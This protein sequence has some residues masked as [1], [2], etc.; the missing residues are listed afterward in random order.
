GRYNNCAR[1]LPK[2]G[3]DVL[4]CWP[5]REET[6]ADIHDASANGRHGQIIN[7]ATWM[8]GG[9][10]F[11]GEHKRFSYPSG[12]KFT[13]KRQDASRGHALRFASDDIYDCGWEVT[14]SV[15]IPA[16]APAGIYKAEICAADNMTLLTD[17]TFLVK[18][19]KQKPRP[20]MLVLCAM[21]T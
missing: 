15:S 19:S 18:R 17:V 10:Q 6:G 11:V 12:C 4:A 13:D 9:P 7:H 20:R 2:L 1:T 3:T 14:D 5:F 8:I 16:S 21:N